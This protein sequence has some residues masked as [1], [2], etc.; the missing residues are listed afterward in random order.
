MIT[1]ENYAKIAAFGRIALR[2]K[3]DTIAVGMVKL[4]K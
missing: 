4:I 2:E 1:V 3:Q